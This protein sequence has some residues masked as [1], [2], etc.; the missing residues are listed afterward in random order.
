MVDTLDLPADPVSVREQSWSDADGGE[1]LVVH[2]IQ[3]PGASTD[4]VPAGM[5][6]WAETEALEK[7]CEA[8]IRRSTPPAA[9]C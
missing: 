3:A 9:T 6:A 5:L 1:V 8:S 7:G 4:E 2:V